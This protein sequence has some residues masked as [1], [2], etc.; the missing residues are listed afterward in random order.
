[1]AA[2]DAV[3]YTRV[4]S[5]EQRKSGYSLDFQKKE[6]EAYALKNHLNIVKFYMESHTAKRPGRP[7]FNEMLTF[8]RKNKIRH[9]IFYHSHRAS[10]N[11]VDSANLV[12]MAEY[13]GY[14]IHLIQNNLLL[15]Q[16]SKPQDY[17]IFEIDNCLANFYPRN[18]S[19]DVSTK[20]R[21]KAEQGYF[22]GRAPVGYINKRIKHRSYIQIDPDKSPFIQMVYDLYATEQYSY[23]SLAAEMRK[24]GFMISEKTPCN[25]CNIEDILNNP[26]Y[27]GDFIWN[28]QR[29]YD[30]K[31]EPIV[32]RELWT[33]CQ[34]IINSR[35]RGIVTKRQFIFSNIMKCKKCGCTMTAEIKKG[36]YIY[37]HCTGNRGG[38]CKK[39]SYINENLVETAFVDILKC[40]E[41]TPET[42]EIVKQGVKFELESQNYINTQ[43]INTLKSDIE[44]T[45]NRLNKL[46]DLYLD[47]Q[48]K[49][50]LYKEKTH[51]LETLLNDYTLQF[52]SYTKTDIE[53]LKLSERLF[54]LCKNAY[55]LYLSGDIK[56]KQQLIKMMCSNFLYD[57][58]TL[59][60][61]IKEVFKPLLEIAKLEKMGMKRFELPR[62][63]TSS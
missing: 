15:N 7:L 59:T 19:V 46:F 38:S 45:K 3:L 37:Y 17:F 34:H 56:E 33:M 1:M 30:G 48:I 22:P 42:L 52:S 6:G 51:E 54:E 13:E 35:I 23:K 44:K 11:G 50:E 14:N 40:L 21:E 49:E 60:I 20:L 8:C 47:G 25:K 39:D 57:G 58:K 62:F 32:S 18:L 24:R 4:S 31:H 43:R 10:R 29:Y 41:L 36:K 9:L 61:T 28:G 55:K 2:N 16:K 63:R 26:I 12:Y 27:M 53:L 5:D